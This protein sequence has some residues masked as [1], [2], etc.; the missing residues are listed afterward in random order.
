LIA[1]K[2][3]VVKYR[4][5]SRLLLL[6]SV[7]CLS[8]ANTV[9]VPLAEYHSAIGFAISDLEPLVDRGG[10][11]SDAEY[12][13]RLTAAI[14]KV[15]VALP[16]TQQVEF[17][18]KSW[19]TDNAWL[20]TALA[21]LVNAAAEE[22]PAKL[23]SVI[24]SLYALNDRVNALESAEKSD[25]E[26]KGAARQKLESILARPEYASESRG[27]NALTKFLRDL[28]RWFQNLMPK[29]DNVA[30]GRARLFSDVVTIVVVGVAGLLIFYVL[31]LLFKRFKLPAKPKV[32]KKREARVVLGER[33]RP[34]QTATDL[35][36]EAEALARNGDLRAA[37]RKGYIA[38]LVELGDRNVISLAQYKTNRDYL[39]SVVNVPQLHSPLKGLT[40]TF[41]RHWY[42]LVQATPNDW[43]DFR[44]RY[45][46]ALQTGN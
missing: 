21:D 36:A 38:L 8:V 34:E 7:L 42:G 12:E 16:K 3:L 10:H 19:T 15:V 5:C 20:H 1:L 31:M 27:S 45:R 32:R 14:A 25:M 23:T 9:A 46:E 28:I 22:R 37:I 11:E 18:K 44:A 43:Q 24:E 6:L 17:E 4:F 35:L 33:L 39:R 2:T 30:P 26:H 29:A 41:E 13:A 40:E